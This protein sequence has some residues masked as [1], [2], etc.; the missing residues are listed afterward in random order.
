MSTPTGIQKKK[1]HTNARRQVIATADVSIRQVQV[2]DKVGAVRGIV[3]WQCGPDIF[4]AD[5]MD[6]MFDA[7]RRKSAP[8]WLVEQIKNLPQ[9]QKFFSDGTAYDSA[10]EVSTPVGSVDTSPD[11]VPGDADTDLPSFAQA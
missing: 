11:H 7:A 3:V 8:P 5:T 10:V 9:S 4:W 6:G 2:I 1:F